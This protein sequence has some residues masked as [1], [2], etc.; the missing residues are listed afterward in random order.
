[1]SSK[2]AT[3]APPQK[4]L[5]T[6]SP[7]FLGFRIDASEKAQLMREASDV[8]YAPSDVPLLRAM[9]ILIKHNGRESYGL[10]FDAKNRHKSAEEIRQFFRWTLGK[11]R[12]PM[13]ALVRK[14]LCVRRAHL[15]DGI[16]S[17]K[18]AD[19]L[20]TAETRLLAEIDRL[21]RDDGSQEPEKV[22]GLDGGAAVTGVGSWIQ[23]AV[24]PP[25]PPTSPSAS[26]D[27]TPLLSKLEALEARLNASNNKQAGLEGVL[28]QLMEALTALG[29]RVA[30]IPDQD[31]MVRA[32]QSLTE[33]LEGMKAEL[34]ATKGSAATTAATVKTLTDEV[35][36]AINDLRRVVSD[37]QGL[38]GPTSVSPLEEN[39]NDTVSVGSIG[40]NATN[41]TNTSTQ[42]P[43]NLA[44]LRNI[45]QNANNANKTNK[46]KNEEEGLCQS[47]DIET[48]AGLREGCL[49]TVLQSLHT[50]DASAFNTHFGAVKYL[51]DHLGRLSEASARFYINSLKRNF[52]VDPALFNYTEDVWKGGYDQLNTAITKDFLALVRMAQK[53][54]FPLNTRIRLTG[55]RGS[56]RRRRGGSRR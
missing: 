9:G 18:T 56:T 5:D 46:I 55:P 15:Q 36:P 54:T 40:S 47:A 13:P 41:R 32:I 43:T 52:N 21:L 16:A 33:N 12:H 10:M 49:I 22:C 53:A 30:T 25:F 19:R 35:L 29:Q 11:E 24:K 1:M 7:T 31:L 23:P 26:V 48:N 50:K 2:N 27:L 45:T 39:E 17:L 37:L 6:V 14:V 4:G 38:R 20:R 51:N 28:A 42:T 8:G 3:P 44:A 34:D